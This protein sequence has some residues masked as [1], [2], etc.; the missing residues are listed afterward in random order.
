MTFLG[1]DVEGRER[2]REMERT[3]ELMNFHVHEKRVEFILKEVKRVEKERCKCK[4]I[5]LSV[6]S[7]N[8]EVV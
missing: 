2:K 1:A 3:V 6:S 8:S 5:D 4:F 7:A